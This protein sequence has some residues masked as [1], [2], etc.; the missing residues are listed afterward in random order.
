MSTNVYR[1]EQ[2]IRYGMGPRTYWGWYI[3]W[4]SYSESVYPFE[5]QERREDWVG[6]VEK[7]MPPGSDS[8]QIEIAAA[9]LACLTWGDEC[10]AGSGDELLSDWFGPEVATALYELAD[11]FDPSAQPEAKP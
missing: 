1:S 2:I 5:T 11:K 9:S 10:H 4:S 6:A 7:A 3:S 8:Y